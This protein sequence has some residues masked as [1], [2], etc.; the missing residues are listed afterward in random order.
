MQIHKK[1]IHEIIILSGEMKNESFL[2]EI[3]E[4][5][6]RSAI[7]ISLQHFNLQSLTVWSSM[8]KI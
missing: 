5:I 4:K 1:F 7:I 2:F 3:K 6:K 8:K